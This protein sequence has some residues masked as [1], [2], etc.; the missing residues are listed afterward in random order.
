MNNTVTFS[1]VTEPP[2]RHPHDS[3]HH[4]HHPPTKPPSS[5]TSRVMVVDTLQRPNS[6]PA[7]CKKYC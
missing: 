7:D 6:Y 3:S 1:L 2:P 5:A 4:T